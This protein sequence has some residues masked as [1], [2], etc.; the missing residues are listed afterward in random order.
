MQIHPLVN[1][2]TSGARVPQALFLRSLQHLPRLAPRRLR[3]DFLVVQRLVSPTNMTAAAHGVRAVV[4]KI[5]EVLRNHI[6]HVF[7]AVSD[8]AAA[9]GVCPAD[10]IPFGATAGDAAANRSCRL[11][12]S[13]A[14][15]SQS[16]HIRSLSLHMDVEARLNS[17]PCAQW[18][19]ALQNRSHVPLS[20]SSS[21]H[22][23]PAL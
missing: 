17:L 15:Y 23:R 20:R 1:Q 21:A 18:R 4:A 11:H 19:A 6:A 16:L 8:A 3:V 10:L 13:I 7:D 22:T 9:V 14:G 5:I 2:T 12:G